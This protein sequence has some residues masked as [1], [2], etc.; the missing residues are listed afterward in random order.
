MTKMVVMHVATMYRC[1]NIAIIKSNGD[2]MD[3]IQT[4]T[5]NPRLAAPSSFCHT[6]ML[7]V[8]SGVLVSTR[9]IS[10][11]LLLPLVRSSSSFFFFL[12]AMMNERNE[13]CLWDGSIN[14]LCPFQTS[15]P[16]ICRNEKRCCFVFE[17]FF[18]NPIVVW[19]AADGRSKKIS[20]TVK[21]QNSNCFKMQR[22]WTMRTMTTT[23]CCCFF[24]A[25]LFWYI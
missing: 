6:V 16:T 7:V 19:P 14:V 8:G 15:S 13:R 1:C 12:V 22:Y 2:A 23:K 25:P 4:T 10:S 5:N 21:V 9:T 3:D 18:E 11:P 17:F 24:A 20:K